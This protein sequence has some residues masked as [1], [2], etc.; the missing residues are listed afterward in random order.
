MIAIIATSTIT[1]I[2]DNAKFRPPT[3]WC[4][5]LYSQKSADSSCLRCVQEH[6]EL[7]EMHWQD[8]YAG[9]YGFW[10]SYVTGVIYRYL[11]CGDL[12]LGIARVKCQDF[13]WLLCL[14]HLSALLLIWT[15]LSIFIVLLD[16]W[17]DKLLSVYSYHNRTTY[18]VCGCIRRKRYKG[19]VA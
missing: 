18:K 16:N 3:W 10:R 1:M 9:H 2:S 19:T 6:Y 8:R 13:G 12:Y 11:K 15:E 5:C 7:L 17:M 4:R 14:Q